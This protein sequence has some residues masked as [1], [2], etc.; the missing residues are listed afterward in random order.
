MFDHK[1]HFHCPVMAT[2]NRIFWSPG[3]SL[4]DFA[5]RH[6]DVSESVLVVEVSDT[7]LYYDKRR[8]AALYAEAGIADYWIINLSNRTLEVRRSPTLLPHGWDYAN[9][10]VYTETQSVTVL[11]HSA[12]TVSV[13][14]LLP[15]ASTQNS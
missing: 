9:L 13:A 11:L 5:L 4:K 10:T 15:L 12:V 6:P 1:D 3:V 14:S 8:K 2:R 7:T